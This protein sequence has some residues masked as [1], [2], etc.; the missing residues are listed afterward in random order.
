MKAPVFL[1]CSHAVFAFV[2]F[3]LSPVP[4]PVFYSGGTSRQQ[5]KICILPHVGRQGA[6][7]TIEDVM[8]SVYL[9]RGTVFG[10]CDCGDETSRGTVGLCRSGISARIN[11]EITYLRYLLEETL[12][13]K[14]YSIEYT[15]RLA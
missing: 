3:P 14:I 8:A 12:R 7:W 11:H 1:S 13:Y 9:L 10:T 15:I 4:F 2:A 6:K 5:V